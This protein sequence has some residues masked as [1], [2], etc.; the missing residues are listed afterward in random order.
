MK[1]DSN[2]NSD[3]NNND[4]NNIS[5]NNN[6]IFSKKKADHEKCYLKINHATKL[7]ILEKKN[8]KIQTYGNP[9]EKRCLHYSQKHSSV[10]T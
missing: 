6:N 3:N 5:N 2:E 4:N 10:K 1:G 9:C 7:Y 8:R